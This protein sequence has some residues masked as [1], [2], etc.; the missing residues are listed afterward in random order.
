MLFRFFEIPIWTFRKFRVPDLLL[1]STVVI[2]ID[3]I[4]NAKEQ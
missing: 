3:T 1:L 2:L 4:N